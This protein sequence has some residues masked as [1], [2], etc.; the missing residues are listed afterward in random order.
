MM[1]CCW[2]N[3]WNINAK[4]LIWGTISYCSTNDCKSTLPTLLQQFNLIFLSRCFNFF[5]HYLFLKFNNFHYSSSYFEFSLFHETFTY[6]SDSE[7]KKFF[8]QLKYKNTSLNLLY[9]HY[10]SPLF[11]KRL[12]VVLETERAFQ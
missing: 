12:Q 1:F 8:Y 10:H 5:L 3:T 7:Q 2:K 4:L 11:Y 6:C 9:D